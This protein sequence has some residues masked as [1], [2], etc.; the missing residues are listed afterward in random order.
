[1]Y[2]PHL[3]TAFTVSVLTNALLFFLDWQIP[4]FVSTVFPLYLPLLISFVLGLVLT[5]LPGVPLQSSS[6]VM[7]MTMAAM[8]GLALGAALWSDLSVFGM[9]RPFFVL[10]LMATPVLLVLYTSYDK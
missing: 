10:A 8:V 7:L 3:L 2:S 5:V 1:M 6:K 4:G 9:W